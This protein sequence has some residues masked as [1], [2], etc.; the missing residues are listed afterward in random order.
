M[1][2]FSAMRAIPKSPMTPL[3]VVAS[4]LCV[5]IRRRQGRRGVRGGEGGAEGGRARQI[6]APE[7]SSS[8]I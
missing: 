1:L 4:D 7:R 8:C 3:L 6:D 2:Q 5:E